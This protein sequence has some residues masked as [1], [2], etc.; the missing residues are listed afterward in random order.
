MASVRNQLGR[1]R[2][3]VVKEKLQ[4]G[5][6]HIIAELLAS[7]EHCAAI[8][9]VCN[10]LPARIQRC[11]QVSAYGCGGGLNDRIGRQDALNF[12]VGAT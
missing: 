8:F 7:S 5:K 12:F 1:H 6:D 10:H 4:V 3:P 11:L 2:L 9:Y